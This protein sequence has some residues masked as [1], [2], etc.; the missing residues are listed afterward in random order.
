MPAWAQTLVVLGTVAGI[1]VL[2]HFVMRHVFR[3]V[4]RT[5]LREL[6][7]AAALLL[8]IGIAILM[9][10]VGLSPALGTFVAGVVLAGSEYRHELESDIDPFKGLLLGLFFIAVGASIDFRI[11]AAGPGRILGLVVAIIAMKIAV[12]LVLARAFKLSLDQGLI[13]AFALSQ[14][15]EFAFVLL[16]F[17]T[18]HGVLRSESAGVLAAAVALTMALTPLLMLISER[19]ILPRVGTKEAPDRESDTIEEDNPVIIAGFG[20]FGQIVGRL[21]RANGIGTTVLE[22]DSDQ[23]D[24]MRRFGHKVYY[25]DALRHDLL[26]TA[27]AGRAKLLILATDVSEKRLEIVHTVKKHFPNLQIY[28]RATSRVDAYELLDAGVEHVYRETFGT[29]LRMG[30]DALRALGFRA[31]RAQ[32]AGQAFQRHD[33]RALRDMAEIR[34][35]K[36]GDWFQAVRE[37][38]QELERVLRA[39]IT[40]REYARDDAWDNETLREDVRKGTFVVPD[41]R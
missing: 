41:D 14:V 32:R 7:T 40:D 33:E 12:V 30:V 10:K 24:I 5:R 20:R 28:A 19:L 34:R 35:R 38:G 6:F 13:F 31:H 18:Q 27:G 15:G 39:D 22:F 1:V 2:G 21:L 36:D 9:T 16:S 29:S 25:G 4:A 23:V 11:V 3:A 26:E 8:V 17:S 37:R